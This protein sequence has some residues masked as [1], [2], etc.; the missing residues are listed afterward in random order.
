MHVIFKK[1]NC[2]IMNA[3]NR[4]INFIELLIYIGLYPLTIN[5]YETFLITVIAIAN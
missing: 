1:C 3:K 2:A 5:F 4:I